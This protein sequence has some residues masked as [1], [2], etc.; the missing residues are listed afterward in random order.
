MG[1]TQSV[2]MML[3]SALASAADGS[4]CNDCE[5]CGDEST[6]KTSTCVMGCGGIVVS[7]PDAE[8]SDVT[9]FAVL[10][11]ETP[12]RHAGCS[13]APNPSPPRFSVLT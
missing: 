11:A 13:F 2:D 4:P 6:V 7:L 1:G 10:F 5:C 12:H 9:V 8:V 3:Q